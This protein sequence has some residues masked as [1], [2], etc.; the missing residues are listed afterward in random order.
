MTWKRSSGFL[1][2]HH[3]SRY[4]TVPSRTSYCT[5]FKYSVLFCQLTPSDENGP[6]SRRVQEHHR[7]RAPEKGYSFSL[8]GCEGRLPSSETP[9]A[10]S[11]QAGKGDIISSGTTPLPS[12]G[13]ASVG[14]SRTSI[15]RPK[16]IPKDR[17]V[18]L[19]SH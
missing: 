15:S 4:G 5:M 2:A 8:A 14:R 1:F 3:Q 16:T 17:E 12:K 19:Q 7:D 18:P 10:S 9:G 11:G 13:R 6:D